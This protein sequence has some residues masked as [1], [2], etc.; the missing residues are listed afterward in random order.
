VSYLSVPPILS[1]LVTPSAFNSFITLSLTTVAPPTIIAFLEPNLFISPL[2][3][4][5]RLLAP[6]K[7]KGA[8]FKGC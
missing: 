5:G 2:V 1:T 6:V 8:F 4:S 7:S 3:P